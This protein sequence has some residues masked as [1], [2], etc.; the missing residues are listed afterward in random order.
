M[1]YRTILLALAALCF[2][3]QASAEPGDRGNHRGEWRNYAGPN[4]RDEGRGRGPDLGQN[5]SPDQARDGVRQGRLRPLSDIK[6]E[7]Q[8][9]H[10][11]ELLGAS[12]VNEGDRPVYLIRWRTGDGRLL[13]LRID[14][15]S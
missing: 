1:R 4:D 10:G 5:W 11:G 2:T 6:A 7:L 9:R 13:D 15:R 3:A 12:L 14:A 8:A